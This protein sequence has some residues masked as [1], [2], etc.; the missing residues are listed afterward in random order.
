M[1]SCFGARPLTLIST[2]RATARLPSWA[3]QSITD[4]AASI[5]SFCSLA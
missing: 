2:M 3:M 4:C 1:G 5:E